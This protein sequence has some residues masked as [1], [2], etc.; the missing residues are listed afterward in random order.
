[1][2]IENVGSTLIKEIIVWSKTSGKS[3][4][5]KPIKINTC[6][7]K[8]VPS[9]ESD[10][11]QTSGG[12]QYSENIL[13]KLKELAGKN[14]SL[15]EMATELGVPFGKVRFLL[16]KHNI[17]TETQKEF[18]VLQEYFSAKTNKSKEKAFASVD[19]Y[20]KQIAKEEFEHSK[21]TTYEDCLQD[22][23]L[24]F[25]E[26]VNKNQQ[27]GISFPH[28]ILQSVRES[29]PALK[30]EVKTVRLGKNDSSVTDTGIEIFESNNFEEHIL[31][32]LRFNMKEREHWIL[33]QYIN[34]NRSIDEIAEHFGLSK[35][36]AQQILND[37][38]AKAKRQIEQVSTNEYL[39]ERAANY[40]YKIA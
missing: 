39:H 26:L 35:Q 12:L 4:L 15:N 20:L 29:K 27:N 24:R 31:K 30:Q 13:A 6:G 22:V 1:M 16:N 36:R 33:E 10:V 3:L 5:T 17:L 38:I 9:L 32:R 7:L 25:F 11:L 37:A 2:G 19:K 21:G 28:K 40:G 34:K 23:R 8:Y 18:R 14:L